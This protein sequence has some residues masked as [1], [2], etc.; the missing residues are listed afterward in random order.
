MAYVD[1]TDTGMDPGARPTPSGGGPNPATIPN[2]LVLTDFYYPLQVWLNMI[3]TVGVG[4]PASWCVS[5]TCYEANSR[6]V[7]YT[8]VGM[9]RNG[10]LTATT[11]YTETFDL[12]APYAFT[13]TSKLKL[14]WEFPN[15]DDNLGLHPPTYYYTEQKP[16]RVDFHYSVQLRHTW[17]AAQTAAW[18]AVSSPMP[19]C[20]AWGGPGTAC[21]YEE[22]ITINPSAA[23]MQMR[24]WLYRPTMEET[25]EG[26]GQ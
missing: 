10:D 19:P 24:M 26:G 2:G 23:P 25:Q 13:T 8:Y 15:I 17:T 5:G 16:G 21:E 14:F 18:P 20:V 4:T 11:P 1:T 3:P 6:P 22:T 7:S 12:A 9:S